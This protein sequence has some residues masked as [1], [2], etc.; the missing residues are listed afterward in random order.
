MIDGPTT[1]VERQFI[2][3]KRVK[4]TKFRI[5]AVNRGQKRQKL[6]D[7]INKFG[8]EEKWGK[9]KFAI[10]LANQQKRQNLSDF[11]RFQVQLLKKQ[12]GKQVR[13][14]VR[15]KKSSILGN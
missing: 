2:P 9:T 11:E 6:I 5:L 14:W 1:N 3:T 8:L 12:L 7:N 10:K 4:L 13:A 15:S